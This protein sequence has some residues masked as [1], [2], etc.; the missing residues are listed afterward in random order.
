[1]LICTL[2]GLLAM[3]ALKVVWDFICCREKPLRNDDDDEDIERIEDV[4]PIKENKT[5]Q[6]INFIK[7]K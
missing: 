1:M 3:L 7:N 2:I 6:T 4:P 5:I